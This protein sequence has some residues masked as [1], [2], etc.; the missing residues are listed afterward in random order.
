MMLTVLAGIIAGTT[1]LIAALLVFARFKILINAD[2]FLAQVQRL[3]MANNIDRAIKLCN[4][5]PAAP[6]A[7]GVKALL[8]RAERPHQL[9]LVYHEALL[10]MGSGGGMLGRL[11]LADILGG[12]LAS[13]AMAA[14]MYLSPG[15]PQWILCLFLGS[16]L[17]NTATLASLVNHV[18][19]WPT[20]LTKIKNVLYSRAGYVPPAYKPLLAGEADPERVEAWRASMD[21]FEQEVKERR[22]EGWAGDASEAHDKRTEDNGILPPL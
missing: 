12:V 21:S 10:E 18:G 22:A 15:I 16:A 5:A 4:A 14:V 17:I 7:E 1:A 19:D 3:V 6:L 20:N 11:K 8:T 9:E 2:A 13:L